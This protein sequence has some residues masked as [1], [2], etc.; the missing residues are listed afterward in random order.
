MFA[1]PWWSRVCLACLA[2][3]R[4]WKLLAENTLDKL[5]CTDNRYMFSDVCLSLSWA[6]SIGTS[7][8]SRWSTPSFVTCRVEHS[9]CHSFYNSLRLQSLW[10]YVDVFEI[11]TSMLSSSINRKHGIARRNQ[12]CKHDKEYV[13]TWERQRKQANSMC[14]R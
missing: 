12:L 11:C 7:L 9:F 1:Q 6:G 4:V 10:F 14:K 8:A 13:P 5:N 2:S 3:R